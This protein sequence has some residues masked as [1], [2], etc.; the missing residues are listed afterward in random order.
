VARLLVDG[1]W[2]DP[3][4]ADSIYESD[5]EDL[6]IA[7]SASLYPNFWVIKYKRVI[8]SEY[9]TAK[10]DLAFIEKN[11]R[12]WYLCEVELGTHDLSGHVVP[13]IMV[14]SNARVGDT[15][16]QYIAGREPHLNAVQLAAMM[17]GEAPGVV[18]LVNH[19]DQSW[20]RILGQWGA[21]VGF[22]E[23]YR[24]TAQRIILRINGDDLSIPEEILSEC[25]RDPVLRNAL[26]VSSPAPLEQRGTP[27]LDLWYEG[28]RTSWK[29]L[30]AGGT[31]WLLPLARFPLNPRDQRFTIIADANDQLWL[32]K[33]SR[34]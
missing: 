28:A 14:F 22:I 18:V 7:H 5:L 2:F 6:I 20:R 11:Y 4:Q 15:E 12:I 31:C 25:M 34:K 16:A 9:G 29:M 24:D 30:R 26:K 3:V 1:R 10:P 27:R 33:G 19:F 23:I 21:L 32:K 13:Q 17:K 8:E